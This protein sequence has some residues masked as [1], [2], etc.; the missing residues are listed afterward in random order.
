VNALHVVEAAFFAFFS[1]EAR[2]P[3]HSHGEGYVLPASPAVPNPRRRRFL[4]T[5]GATSAGAAAAPLAASGVVGEATSAT[6]SASGYR[7]TDHVRD[8]YDSARI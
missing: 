8:Y 2:M 6:S 4:L 1:E 3:A 7:E 5:L